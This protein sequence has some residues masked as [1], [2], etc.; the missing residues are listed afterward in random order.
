MFSRRKKKQTKSYSHKG[1]VIK[2][3]RASYRRGKGVSTKELRK[4]NLTPLLLYMRKR[5]LNKNNGGGK[6]L[7]DEGTDV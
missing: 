5:S 6:G 7:R 1:E 4:G 2:T 3:E